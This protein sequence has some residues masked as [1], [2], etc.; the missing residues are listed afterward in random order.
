[1]EKT[2]V[3]QKLSTTKAKKPG[4]QILEELLSLTSTTGH[5]IT[6]TNLKP[7]PFAFLLAPTPCLDTIAL[8]TGCPLNK[9]QRVHNFGYTHNHSYAN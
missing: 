8:A 4:T 9:H 3:C 7:P 2:Y 6:L 5:C 1:M